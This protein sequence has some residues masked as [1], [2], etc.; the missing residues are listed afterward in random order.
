MSWTSDTYGLARKSAWLLLPISYKSHMGRRNE[1][2]KALS[3]RLLIEL[4][5]VAFP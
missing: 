4:Q 3:W 2:D 5:H 1:I